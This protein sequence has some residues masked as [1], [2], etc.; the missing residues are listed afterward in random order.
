M[1]TDK[2]QKMLNVG[3]K[4]SA[5]IYPGTEIVG[6]LINIVDIYTCGS[7]RTKNNDIFHT[8]ISMIRKVG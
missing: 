6:T 2:K 7:I 5:L 1:K 4:V 8:P 3:D